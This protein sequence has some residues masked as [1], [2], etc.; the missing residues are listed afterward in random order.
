MSTTE[1]GSVGNVRSRMASAF[2]NSMRFAS[3]FTDFLVHEGKP[4]MADSAAGLVALSDMGVPDADFSVT[5]QDIQYFFA[6]YVEF[7]RPQERVEDYW[8]TT[9]VPEFQAQ[10]PVDRRMTM[11]AKDAGIAGV[12]MVHLRMSLFQFGEG[13]TGMVMRVVQ[14]PPELAKVGL[15]KFI[16]DGVMTRPRG[17]LIVT[18]PT[19]SGKSSTARS[20]LR[21]HN[22]NSCM[23]IETIEDPIELPMPSEKSLV[24]QRQVG[25]DV[26]SFGSGLEQ[27]MRHSPDIIL[28]SEIRGQDAAEAAIFGGESGT[29]MVV[30]TH[31][32]SCLGTLRK[33]LAMCGE[34]SNAMR[35]VLAGSLIGVVRQELV[36]H[37]DLKGY[38]MVAETLHGTKDVAR[39]LGV[40]DWNALETLCSSERGTPDFVPMR[41]QVTMLAMEG[42][43]D[44]EAAER[45]LRRLSVSA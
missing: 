10:L 25:R 20:I 32:R 11:P 31:G 24:T 1:I 34:N 44:K 29:L 30:T 23:H 18:G 7:R 43:I 42:K 4:I 15:T 45:H 13:L 38:S 40:G 9:V 26:K 8:N 16:L 19:A 2:L 37:K 14:P 35:A 3:Q 5:L 21:H 36:P 39:L 6:H 27:A 41:E 33:V 28:A 12:D 17:L 22:A